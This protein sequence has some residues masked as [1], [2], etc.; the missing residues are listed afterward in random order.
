MIA[1]NTFLFW[2]SALDQDGE[3]RFFVKLSAP[4]NAQIVDVHEGTEPFAPATKH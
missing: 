1:P 4:H 2:W 3:Q